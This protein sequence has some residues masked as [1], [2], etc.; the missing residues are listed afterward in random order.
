MGRKSIHF[1]EGNAISPKS[2]FARPVCKAQVWHWWKYINCAK[3]PS[4]LSMNHWWFSCFLTM[5]GNQK[6][7]TWKLW[8]MPNKDRFFQHPDYP[9]PKYRIVCAAPNL[10]PHGGIQKTRTV[11][12][13]HA[14]R[15]FWGPKALREP[16][17]NMIIPLWRGNL[18]LV[19]FM[20]WA[21]IP[22]GNFTAQKTSKKTRFGTTVTGHMWENI[23]AA[24]W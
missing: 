13:G 15:R 20:T 21:K 18:K 10:K 6:I 17:R 3:E 19:G 5:E 11:P 4:A 9:P 16:I 14:M 12:S 23:R 8:R 7:T 2:F 24:M 1:N 22:I